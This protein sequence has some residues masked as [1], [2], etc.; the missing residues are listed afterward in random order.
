[1]IQSDKSIFIIILLILYLQHYFKGEVEVGFLI[2][3]HH[4]EINDGVSLALPQMTNLKISYYAL[5]VF[6]KWI[7]IDVVW[8]SF[9]LA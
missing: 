4:S 2:C 8:M 7:Y 3:V 9:T 1:M 6:W 5:R